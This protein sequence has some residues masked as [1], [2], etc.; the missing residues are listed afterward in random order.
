M[1]SLFIWECMDLKKEAQIHLNKEISMSCFLVTKKSVFKS[2]WIM[3]I[4][5]YHWVSDRYSLDY[6]IHINELYSIYFNC[7]L[8]NFTAH[9]PQLKELKILLHK[10]TWALLRLLLHP[11][12]TLDF[13]FEIGFI[14]CTLNEPSLF[15]KD[16]NLLPP[17][18]Y[19]KK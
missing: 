15:T 11:C 9:V 19:D 10:F 1:L 17:G 16:A 18:K 14:L 8:D 13:F 5:L 6:I 12:T 7:S 2:S 3:F 4:K